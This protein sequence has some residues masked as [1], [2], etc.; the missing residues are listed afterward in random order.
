MD[1][2]AQR[3]AERRAGGDVRQHA[4]HRQRAMQPFALGERVLRCR[5]RFRGVKRE[6][7][8][9][10]RGEHRRER[11]RDRRDGPGPEKRHR[12]IPAASRCDQPLLALPHRRSLASVALGMIV[13]EDVQ[14]TVD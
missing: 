8:A 4:S 1:A 11:R 7:R 6:Q 2:Q 13:A 10:G 5:R 14:C 9:V 12:A 3:L